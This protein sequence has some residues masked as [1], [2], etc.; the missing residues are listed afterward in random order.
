MGLERKAAAATVGRMA[1][2]CSAAA[3]ASAS[4][5]G[6]STATPQGTART[7]AVQAPSLPLSGGSEYGVVAAP[8]T[9]LRPVV[10]LL[11]VPAIATAGKPPPVKLR[12]DE[13]GATAVLVR[14]TVTSLS[15]RK[16][17][18]VVSMGW[19][20]TGRTLSVRW[21]AGARLAPGRYHVSL[22]A[23]DSHA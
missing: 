11:S 23:Q 18:I 20:R 7:G 3:P 8:A 2:A 9:V 17:V 22:T 4:G 1:L 14:V 21:P 10:G 15:T 5:S 19:V 13:P 16:P 6:A 12:I